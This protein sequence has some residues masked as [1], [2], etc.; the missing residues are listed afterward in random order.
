MPSASAASKRACWKP[1]H[2]RGTGRG[3]RQLEADGGW[4]LARRSD[5]C[6]HVTPSTC[7][8]LPPKTRAGRESAS[9]TYGSNVDGDATAN[10]V[11][12]SVLDGYEDPQGVRGI[13]ESNNAALLPALLHVAASTYRPAAGHRHR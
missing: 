8:H 3:G 10:V 11:S 12:S 5:G 1:R 13:H 4:R 2:A 6:P 7:C 9:R